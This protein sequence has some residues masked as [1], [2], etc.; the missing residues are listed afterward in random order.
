VNLLK[1]YWHS[2]KLSFESAVQI[3][4]VQYIIVDFEKDLGDDKSYI[5]LK[6]LPI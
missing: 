3:K 5:Q 4:N 1:N 2:L 6:L